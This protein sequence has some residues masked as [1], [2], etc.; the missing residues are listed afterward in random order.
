MLWQRPASGLVQP[1]LQAASAGPPGGWG[2][3][4]H[5]CCWHILQVGLCAHVMRHV[6]CMCAPR[7]ATSWC[8]HCLTAAAAGWRTFYTCA[9]GATAY[10][11]AVSALSHSQRSARNNDVVDDALGSQCTMLTRFSVTASSGLEDVMD[12]C[13]VAGSPVWPLHVTAMCGMCWTA[14]VQIAPASCCK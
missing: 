12:E 3:P 8:C 10:V 11:D 1:D 6:S 4:A 2:H 9:L 7:T 14:A 5:A 13:C